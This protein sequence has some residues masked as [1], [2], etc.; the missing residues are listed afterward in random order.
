MS[1]CSDTTQEIAPLSMDSGFKLEM[2][3]SRVFCCCL[4]SVEG[5]MQQSIIING[6]PVDVIYITDHYLSFTVVDLIT[7][8]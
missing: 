4:D 7:L 8:G 5:G 2:T 3:T 1:Q 6:T